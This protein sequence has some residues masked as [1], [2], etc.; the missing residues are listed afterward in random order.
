M[1]KYKVELDWQ[2]STWVDVE[3]ENEEEAK[4]KAKDVMFETVSSGQVSYHDILNIQ[5]LK[6]AEDNID[7]DAVD[8]SKDE[9]RIAKEFHEEMQQ[10]N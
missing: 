6:C 8:I 7:K 1:K 10:V 4:D 5:G 3:A 9:E 2:Y